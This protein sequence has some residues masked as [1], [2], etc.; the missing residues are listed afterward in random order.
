MLSLRSLTNNLSNLRL[1]STSATVF[2]DSVIKSGDLSKNEIWERRRKFATPQ[3]QRSEKQVSKFYYA[4]KWDLKATKTKDEPYSPMV[5][6]MTTPDKWEY[7]NK[8]II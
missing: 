1:L 3:I 5:R 4:P 7:Q 2:T 8:V 6:C